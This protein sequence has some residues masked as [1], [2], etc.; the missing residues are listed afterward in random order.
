MPAVRLSTY[1]PTGVLRCNKQAAG[2]QVHYKGLRWLLAWRD[3]QGGACNP[4]PLQAVV[5]PLELGPPGNLSLLAN[6]SLL[7]L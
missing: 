1:H 2:L 7:A 5:E 3:A 6:A 4:L